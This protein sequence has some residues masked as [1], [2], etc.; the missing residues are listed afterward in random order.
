LV[1]SVV[2]AAVAGGQTGSCTVPPSDRF[3][4]GVIGATLRPDGIDA[5]PRE[6][7]T[8]LLEAIGEQYPT[9]APVTLGTYVT[10]VTGAGATAFTA[11]G[12]TV[13]DAGAIE[14]LQLEAS[15]LSPSFDRNV[16]TALKAAAAAG[17]PPMPRHWHHARFHLEVA[18]A[19]EPD[20]GADIGD[21]T[22]AVR[23]HWV[24]TQL[25]TWPHG[26]NAAPVPGK[27]NW[28]PYPELARR[29]LVEDSVLIQFVVGT[30]GRVTPGTAIVMHAGYRD[31]VRAI[32]GRLATFRYL[33][34]T[35]NGC[36]VASLV[37]EPFVFKIERR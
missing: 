6:Y 10:S 5:P 27:Q 33:P 23:M 31:F 25:P 20:T 7:A 17:L 35:I 14:K 11:V 3:A 1:V 26:L 12:F 21:T 24:S 4:P 32:A 19:A 28:L 16:V 9:N 15:S 30:D 29:Q 37:T 22:N 13:T 8:A 18:T 36:P 34:A 2:G